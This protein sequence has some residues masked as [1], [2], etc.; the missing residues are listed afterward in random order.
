VFK[1]TPLSLTY[2]M[3][4]SKKLYWTIKFLNWTTM[5]TFKVSWNLMNNICYGSSNSSCVV[6]LSHYKMFISHMSTHG[7]CATIFVIHNQSFPIL[8]KSLSYNFLLDAMTHNTLHSLRFRT[9]YN[10]N[11]VINL[12]NV[13]VLVVYF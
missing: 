5:A 13:H 12:K 9:I 11:M 3:T 7:S 6:L 8:V 2:V 4:L 1:L 10:I